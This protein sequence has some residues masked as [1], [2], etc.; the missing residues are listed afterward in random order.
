MKKMIITALL[1]MVGSVNCTVGLVNGEKPEKNRYADFKQLQKDVNLERSLFDDRSLKYLAN[2]NIF[3]RM[4][5]EAREQQDALDE[6]V[7]V[8]KKCRANNNCH[9]SEEFNDCF[10]TFAQA[11]YKS[12]MTWM[13][14]E[15]LIRN[16]VYDYNSQ[17]SR[18]I[19]NT[20]ANHQQ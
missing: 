5:L 8:E 6:L 19:F 1:L 18:R 9:E 12:Y 7:E 16:M 13:R 17:G 3:E 14:H 11:Y 4:L 10:D 2:S 20:V 15:S